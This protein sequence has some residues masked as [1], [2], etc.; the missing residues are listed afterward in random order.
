[1][2]R[3]IRPP[4]L[5]VTRRALL[6]LP[7][8]LPFAGAA[9]AAARAI[10]F[11]RTFFAG[12]YFDPAT[13]PSSQMMTYLV[14]P[15]TNRSSAP[16]GP[17]AN[18][19][20]LTPFVRD[21]LTRDGRLQA[22]INLQFGAD[23]GNPVALYLARAQHDVYSF[24]A[25]PSAPLLVET[26]VSI[27]LS[28][29]VFTDQAAWSS[30]RRFESLFSELLVFEVPS[31]TDVPLDSAALAATYKMAFT[32]A[33]HRLIERAVPQLHI[34][35][36]LAKA[37]FQ[38]TEFR[39]QPQMSVQMSA[40]LTDG[41]A[42]AGLAADA[43]A[44]DRER[45]LLKRELSHMLNQ[46]I[47][48]EL[49]RRAVRDIV[50]LPPESPWSDG[51]VLN[52]LRNRLGAPTDIKLVNSIPDVGIAAYDVIGATLADVD[53]LHHAE[54]GVESRVYGVRLA[55][56]IMRTPPGGAAYQVP[57]NIADPNRKTALG[58]AGEPYLEIAGATR[59]SR[60]EVVLDAFR[61][62]TRDLAGPAVDL[63]VMTAKE[64][65]R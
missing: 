28:L 25:N 14:G 54:G 58:T 23:E 11:R 21:L 1:M 17:P 12:A 44:M 32:G 22:A 15:L 30:A 27:A 45:R 31:E 9:R 53:Q 2:R 8:A 37:A 48:N 57:S 10:E 26:V 47:V 29:D 51:H 60:R 42:A 36:T 16:R 49:Q 46:A 40:V 19:N 7:F 55:A 56:R 18:G 62:A 33:V 5:S 20:E 43:P 13:A 64:I 65:N 34:D 39:L 4:G 3:S 41:L 50:M 59:S 38:V 6:A 35:R 63:M 52:V 61:A 24:R